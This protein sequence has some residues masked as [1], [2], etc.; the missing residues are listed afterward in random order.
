M[1]SHYQ[2]VKE[3]ERY[4]RQFG[5]EPPDDL[6]RYDVWPGYP[7]PFIRRHPH[8]D[9]GDEAV[10]AREAVLGLYGLIPRWAQDTSI[11]RHTFNSRS[12]TVAQK[13]SFRDAWA[14][15][16]HCIVPAE[17]FY[18]PD[19]RSG[20]A[21]ATRIER[22]D[23]QPMGLAGLWDSWRSPDGQQVH[24][25]TLLTIN[26]ND[27]PLMRHLHKPTDEKRMVVILNEDRY[28]DWLQASPKDSMAFLQ[29]YPADLMTAHA[30][31]ISR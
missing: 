31:S 10:P 29:P 14:K 22:A 25:F 1:C 15:R 12:E 3:R 21:V 6:G 30:E 13:P 9:V 26:A 18:E 28:E 23:G 20:R 4:R 16:R 11:G 24:S 7:A 27:H 5:V 8:A 19:W 2:S 17:A